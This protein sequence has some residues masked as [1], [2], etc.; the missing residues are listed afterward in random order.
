MLTLFGMFARAST[1]L[2]ATFVV[3]IIMMVLA[4]A[5]FPQAIV[6]MQDFIEMLDERLRNP[7]I[8]EQAK[9][10]YR[11]LV[12]ENTMFGIIMTIIA[13]MVVE[14]I[15]WAGGSIWKAMGHGGDA[16]TTGNSY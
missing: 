9:V 14:L 7:P 12:N 3:V 5:F 13:R 10:L 15:A 16:P 4:F 8:Q 1:K 6:W 11:T 2:L